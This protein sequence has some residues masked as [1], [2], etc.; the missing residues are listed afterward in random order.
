MMKSNRHALTLVEL[1]VGLA[2]F[3][4]IGAVFV[5]F[6][7]SS[8]KEV[9]FSGD[10]FNAVILSQKVS[11]DVL[12][13]LSVNPYGLETLGVDGTKSGYQEVVDGKS[14]FFS[15]LEDRVAPW[16]KIE[17]TTDG[18]LNSDMKPL[19]DHVKKYKFQVAGERMHNTG[20]DPKRNLMSCD[21][22]FNWSSQTGRGEFN[23]SFLLFSPATARKTDLAAIVDQSAIDARIPG[24]VFFRPGKT[25]PE[26]A[27]DI[28]ENVDTLLAL[29]RISLVSR[30]FMASQYYQKRRQDIK[31]AKLQLSATPQID[32]A[33]QF[34]LRKTIA[35][36]WYDLAKTC[37]QVIA[38][39]EPQFAVLQSQGKFGTGAGT[40]FS[41]ITTSPYICTKRR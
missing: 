39:L 22:D 20:D 11:E 14:V 3:C 41:P 6:I 30:D 12:E 27:A 26:L 15:Y 38:Y 2:I 29:G 7:T 13:E 34:E 21:I 24:E 40:G 19:Y 5:T 9:K 18:L 36:M 33:N 25:V 4:S 23:T 28:G 17:P 35:R 32:L 8:S 10:H 31:L 16:G 1:I 37:F